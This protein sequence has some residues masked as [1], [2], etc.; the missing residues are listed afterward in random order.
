MCVCVHKHINT[1]GCV[2]V[3]FCCHVAVAFFSF[4][5]LLS[6]KG[7]CVEKK[8]FFFFPSESKATNMKKRNREKGGRLESNANACVNT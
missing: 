8:S 3:A 2:D 1:G 7:L 6:L 4:L 5:V